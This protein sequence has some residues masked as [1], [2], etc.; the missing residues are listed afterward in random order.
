MRL[1]HDDLLLTSFLA[2]W[3]ARPASGPELDEVEKLLARAE[4]HGLAGVISDALQRDGIEVPRSSSL[5]ELARELDSRAQFAQVCAIDDVFAEAAAVAVVLKGPLFAM[6][7]YPRPAARVSSDVDLLVR[8]RDL[9]S[10]SSLLIGMG[11]RPGAAATE[12]R[13]RREHHHLHFTHPRLLPLE[14]HFHAYRGFGRTLP[15]EP[16]IIRSVPFRELKAI[17][18]L[19]MEDELVYLA[20]HGAA[21]KFGRWSWLFDLRMMIDTMADTQLYD[22]AKRA[23]ELGFARPLA[24]AAQLLVSIMG[25][26][27]QK[28]AP[29]GHLDPIRAR[30]AERLLESPRSRPLAALSRLL[31]TSALCSDSTTT[32]KWI[33]DEL[34]RRSRQFFG[35][36]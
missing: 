11:Y 18:V 12:E 8:E 22:A 7:F 17:R 25:M 33:A 20:T 35:D 5:L 29:L 26:D 3:P 9:T 21:H 36:S 30:L 27:P 14:L 19:S 1:S 23:R 13:F 15:S 10:A 31:F 6:R 24:L 34:I 32:A 28:V 16:L 2:H 4:H